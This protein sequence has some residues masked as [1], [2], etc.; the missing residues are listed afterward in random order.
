MKLRRAIPSDLPQLQAIS[1]QAPSAPQWS[2]QQW[3]DIWDSQSPARLAWIAEDA[4][5]NIL[6]SAAVDDCGSAVPPVP[7]VG[8]LVAQAGIDYRAQAAPEWELENIVVA[9]A[10]SRRGVGR[11]LLQAL[12]HEARARQA[13]RILLEV[14]ASNLSAIALYL[15]NGFHHLTQRRDYYRDPTEDALILVQLL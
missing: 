7:A 3:L 4:A 8:F 12:L 11:A 5:E 6:A 14:R 1:R 13:E 9:P 15:G 10:F 2:R